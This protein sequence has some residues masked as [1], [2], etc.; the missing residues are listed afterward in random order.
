MKPKRKA[1]AWTELVFMLV[2]LTGTN[3][4]YLEVNGQL[5]S[6]FQTLCLADLKFQAWSLV[7][8]YFVGVLA[9]LCG[10]RWYAPFLGGISAYYM[11]LTV[12]AIAQVIGIRPMFQYLR[13]GVWFCFAGS[14]GLLLCPLLSRVD[15]AIHKK[16]IAYWEDE[17]F[18]LGERD[19]P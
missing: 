5:Y 19:G 18:S 12:A 10:M 8:G 7:G 2:V 11:G 9:A 1:P 13:S 4:P 14:L 16:I 17:N 6:L 3:L 15:F